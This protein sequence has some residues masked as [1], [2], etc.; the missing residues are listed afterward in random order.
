[1]YG[2]EENKE[3]G[4]GGGDRGGKLNQIEVLNNAGVYKFIDF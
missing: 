1:M 2:F 4:I 3:K